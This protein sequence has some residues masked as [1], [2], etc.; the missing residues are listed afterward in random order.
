MGVSARVDDGAVATVEDFAAVFAALPT[1][2]LV[3]RPGSDLDAGVD[4]LDRLAA[5]L[6]HLPLE[7]LCD[8]LVARLVDGH[9][10]DDVAL[11]AV[12]QEGARS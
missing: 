3:E 2:Y 4:R 1:A 5:E 7:E 8:Q 11:V 12:R 6:V 10:S 9:P